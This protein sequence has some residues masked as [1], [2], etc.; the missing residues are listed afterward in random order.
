MFGAQY[1]DAVPVFRILSLNYFISGTFR[2]LSGN[3]LVTQRKLKFNLFVAVVSSAVN[4]IANFLFI[5]WWGAIGAAI[6]TVLVVVISSILST[7]YLII[8]F[9]RNCHTEEE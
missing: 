8:T 3:L 4:I 1:L 2:I 5:Q 7:T 6:A 9:K